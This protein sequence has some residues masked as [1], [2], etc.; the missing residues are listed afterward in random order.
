[1]E[2]LELRAKSIS[3]LV[4]VL[5]AIGITIGVAIA[6]GMM[7]PELISRNTP[8]K[9]VL[10]LKGTEATYDFSGTLWIEV[11][12]Q[13]SGAEPARISNIT[14][15]A[16]LPSGSTSNVALTLLTSLSNVKPNSYFKAVLRSTSSLT[17][18]PSKIA[19]SI[20]YCFADNVCYTASEV[21]SVKT[22]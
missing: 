12:G 8:K 4:A 3:N 14:V 9:G 18:A 13:Y 5:I 15:I 19:V 1:M 10:T 6:V 11:R 16:Y 17:P 20:D 7:M 2:V 21:V 22:T